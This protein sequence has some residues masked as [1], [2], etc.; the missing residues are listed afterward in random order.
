MEAKILINA[1]LIILIVYL[2]LDN[3]PLRFKIGIE[4]NNYKNNYKNPY[5]NEN[6]AVAGV[7]SPS[8]FLGEEQSL[9]F[10]N[11][12]NSKDDSLSFLQENFEDK[13]INQILSSTEE[14]A[15]QPSNYWLSNDNTPNYGSNVT[16]TASH[17]EINKTFDGVEGDDLAKSNYNGMEKE[18]KIMKD[19]I[20]DKQTQQTSFLD[21][22][23]SDNQNTFKPDSWLYKDELPMNGG[24]F[25]GIS[26]FDSMNDSMAVYD[27]NELNIGK[28]DNGLCPPTDDLRNGVGIPGHSARL[29]NV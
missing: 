10:L 23:T 15:I 25:N 1:L 11:D 19:T 22:R 29:N 16:D 12:V 27:V 3:I 4:K 9:S 28:C 2:I 21:S 13:N 18:R 14:P 6:F 26:G 5:I 7:V 8:T 17:Y 20:V 24:L